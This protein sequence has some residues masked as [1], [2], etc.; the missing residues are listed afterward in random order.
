MSIKYS[1]LY[2]CMYLYNLS[3]FFSPSIQL[4]CHNFATSHVLCCNCY[5]CISCLIF[6]L[7]FMCVVWF[8]YLFFKF[9]T[10]SFSVSSTEFSLRVGF[11]LKW[12]EMQIWLVQ[13]NPSDLRIIDLTPVWPSMYHSSEGAE[14]FLSSGV[15]SQGWLVCCC[16]FA[17]DNLGSLVEWGYYFGPK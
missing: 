5:S 1:F 8:I 4:T 9:S 14:R 15:S 6:T 12:L 3:G 10:H 16:S 2:S 17:H 7:H 11:G 13:S